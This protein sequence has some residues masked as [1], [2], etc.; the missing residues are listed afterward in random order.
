MESSK[1]TFPWQESVL[2]W[3]TS[4]FR[5][6]LF[7][8]PASNAGSQSPCG[9]ESCLSTCVSM[10]DLATPNHPCF[11]LGCGILRWYG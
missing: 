3:V 5:F 7:F 6:C 10:K 11:L 8:C 1:F 4:D 2:K 9:V